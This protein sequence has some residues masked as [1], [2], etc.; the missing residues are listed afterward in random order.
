MYR[1]LLGC[2]AGV[3]LGCF[4]L[5]ASRL[6]RD[7]D[8]RRVSRTEAPK[9][10]DEPQHCREGLPAGACRRPGAASPTPEAF[11]GNHLSN[12]TRLTQVFFKS[13]E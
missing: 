9:I 1:L 8:E 7:K 3:I 11:R 4:S 6:R 12:T 13:D 5:D 2:F 10:K